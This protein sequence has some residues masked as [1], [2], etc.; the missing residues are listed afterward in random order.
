MGLRENFQKLI[1]KKQLEIRGLE[2]QM[3][4][5]QAYIQALQDSMRLLPRNLSGTTE[6]TL[7]PGSTLAKTRDIL[8]AAGVPMAVGEILKALGKPQDK[9]HRVSLTGTLSGY[10]RKGKIFTK[11]KNAPNTFGL[12]EFKTTVDEADEEELP[13][14]FGSMTQ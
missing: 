13:E 6:Q 14:E 12:I 9:K 11:D 1:D 4:E 10:A 7:R 5:A 8:K 3:R 2:L